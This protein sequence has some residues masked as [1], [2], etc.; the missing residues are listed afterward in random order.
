[1]HVIINGERH[2]L[3]AGATVDD[4]LVAIGA[5]RSGVAVAVDGGVVPRADWTLTKLGEDTQ[6]EVLTAVQGG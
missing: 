2:E 4:A 6:V 3:P 5:P 1:M